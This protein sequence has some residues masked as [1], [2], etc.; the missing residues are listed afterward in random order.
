MVMLGGLILVP[1]VA[2][3]GN[4]WMETVKQIV[5]RQLGINT[6]LSTASL[7][8]APL[9]VPGGG[10]GA[11]MSPLVPPVVALPATGLS[12]S[13]ASPASAATGWPAMPSLSVPAPATVP[14]VAAQGDQGV[15]ATMSVSPVGSGVV[16]ATGDEA[17]RGTV[18]ALAGS[19]QVASMASLAPAVSVP[20]IAPVY[21]G[22]MNLVPV[23]RT[24]GGVS[25]AIAAGSS[26][27]VAPRPAGEDARPLAAIQ[28]TSVLERPQGPSAASSVDR[29]RSME[30]R[31]R[32]MG[33][34][35]C[36]LESWGPQWEMYRFHCKVGVGGSTN[37]TRSFEATDVDPLAAVGKVV[38]QV[39]QWR[40]VR[41]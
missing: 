33:A 11:A 22:S 32:Q 38:E 14:S 29:F 36:L 25:E 31:L 4:G 28:E 8:E 35:Y 30:L 19:G 34:T 40:T 39:E 17:S 15:I 27:A 7:A 1:A 3:F 41:Q 2:L 23:P 18:G 13:N 5:Q 20:S 10:K 24:I 9:F 21:Q 26:G 16:R 12:A 37:F 6:A